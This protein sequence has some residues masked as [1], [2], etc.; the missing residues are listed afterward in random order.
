[1]SL[2]EKLNIVKIYIKSVKKS[3]CHI[4]SVIGIF[5][6]NTAKKL[7]SLICRIGVFIANA[8]KKLI[9]NIGKFIVFVFKN[10]GKGLLNFIILTDIFIKKLKKLTLFIVGKIGVF[11]LKV[12]GAIKL[13]FIKVKESISRIGRVEV[14]IIAAL[15]I[16][17]VIPLLTNLFFRIEAKSNQVNLY[18]SVS[19]EEIFGK[20]L[21]E[22]LILEFEEK[23]PDIKLKFAYDSSTASTAHAVEPDILFFNEGDFSALIAELALIE[24]NSFTNYE[25]A[26]RQMA[27]P[28]VSFMDM[29]F[30]NI[31]ILSAAGFD[32]PPKT[33]DEFIAYARTVSR[34]NSGAAGYALSLSQKDR[35]ALS[36]D[37]FSWIWASGGSFISEE[38]GVQV[39]NK[40]ST[41]DLSF[42][43]TLNKEGMLTPDIFE[44]TGDERLDAFVQGKVAL[45]IASTRVI[46][47]L[48]AKM[49]DSVFGITTIPVSGTAGKYTISVSSI[50]TGIFANTA[51]PQEAWSFLEFLA[52]KSHLL[53]EELKA[54][55]G[56]V[57][58]IIP[59]DY[60]KDDLFYSKAWDIFEA[61]NIMKKFSVI[62]EAQEYENNLLEELKIFFE[63]DQSASN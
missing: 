14:F 42:F 39:L 26:E 44:T 24:L 1:M 23:N 4:L 19:G 54:V 27:I 15:L 57:S 21:M 11:F 25:S 36:R 16:F 56:M 6:A 60:V 47:Y 40:L 5:F 50:Y 28:L 18:L 8:V 22:K 59:G 51:H 46:P 49:G 30:Y 17:I 13:F 58:N 43:G 37:V 63:N 12:A 7:V 31:D 3:I 9:F 38:E 10:V 35:Q 34:G 41:N 55:P 33:R 61:G 2:L 62:P 20:E 53:C 45:M 29:L 48:R 52:S 32:H